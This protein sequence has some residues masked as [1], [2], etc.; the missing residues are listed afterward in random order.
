MKRKNREKEDDDEDDAKRLDKQ[1]PKP[2]RA[3]IENVQKITGASSVTYC[4]VLFFFS[5]STRSICYLFAV[6][7]PNALHFTAKNELKIDKVE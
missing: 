6:K 1:V 3:K 7:Q 4:K 2:K 5:Q